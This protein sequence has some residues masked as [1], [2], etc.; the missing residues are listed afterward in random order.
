MT[1]LSTAVMLTVPIGNSLQ[2]CMVHS[3]ENATNYELCKN[4]T[5]YMFHPR[6][7]VK[8]VVQDIT[9]RHIAVGC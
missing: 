6:L 9:I 2:L 3:A 4:I 7:I 5:L 1:A 8:T